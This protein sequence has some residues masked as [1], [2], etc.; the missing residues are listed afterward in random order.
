MNMN[1]VMRTP[2]QNRK[3][4]FLCSRLGIDREML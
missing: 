2:E 3:L 1:N 4:H